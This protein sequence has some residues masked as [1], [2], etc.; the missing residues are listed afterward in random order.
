M[1]VLFYRKTRKDAEAHETPGKSSRWGHEIVSHVEL[2]VPLSEEEAKEVAPYLLNGASPGSAVTLGREIAREKAEKNRLIES[3]KAREQDERT[4][5]N[6]QF[7]TEVGE[8]N[9]EVLRGAIALAFIGLAVFSVLKMT[10]TSTPQ[11][12]ETFPT[13]QPASSTEQGTRTPKPRTSFTINNLGGTDACKQGEGEPLQNFL[14]RV[15]GKK[16]ILESKTCNNNL[17]TITGTHE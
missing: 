8:T 1:P 11:I 9:D 3:Q 15:Y 10:P 5:A 17:A 13:A 7:R 12:V 14:T 2:D 4:L 16:V 6:A